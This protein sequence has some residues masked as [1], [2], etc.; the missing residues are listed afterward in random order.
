LPVEERA[1]ERRSSPLLDVHRELGAKLVDFASWEMPL[2]FTGIVA[3]HR[4]VRSDAGIFD[5]SHLGKLRVAGAS[6]G[7]ALQR[8]LTADIDSLEAG[9]AVYSLALTED[10]GCVDDLFVYRLG[11]EELLLVPNAANVH[12]VAEAVRGTGGDPIDEWDRWAIIAVQGPKSFVV[13]EKAFPE[14]GA[15]SLDMHAFASIDVRGEPGLVARTGYTGERGFELFAPAAT[16]PA[17][18]RTLLECGGTPAGLGA[19]D[20]L[21]LE[22]GYALY[23]HEIDRDVNPIEAGL[24][25][26]LAWDTPFVGKDAVAR[27]KEQGPARRLV[28][29]R[30][31]DR[32]IPRRGYSVWADGDRIGEVTSGNFSPTLNTGIAL[33]LVA[34]DRRPD[35]G[36]TVEVEARGRKIRGDIVKP[37]FVRR[38]AGA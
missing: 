32:G 15:P 21:R 35:P 23:G 19:R 18:F 29:I 2:Q 13:F 30:C 5:V 27:V 25:W 3:E 14:S 20:T 1:A 4:A 10:G 6:A 34:A 22:M 31:V 8:A 36:A 16:A 37:P 7:P 12:P 9:R 28:G 17:A 11:D 38:Q 24:A 33:A 26:V